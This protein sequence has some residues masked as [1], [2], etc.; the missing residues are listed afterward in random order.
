MAA[1]CSVRYICYIFS[2]MN[3]DNIIE[4]KYKALSKLAHGNFEAFLYDC[5]GTLADNMQ[6]HKDSYVKVALDNGIEI[7]PEIIDEFAGYP[8]PAV[9]EEINKRY[10]CSFDPLEFEKLKSTLFYDRYIEHTK[11]IEYVV[12]HLK[13]HSGKVKIGV[14]SGG[15]RVMIEKTLQV[16]GIASMVEVLVCAGETPNGKPFP[17]PFLLAAQKLAV[18]PDKCLVFEDGEPGVQA[19]IA[20]GMKWIRIDKVED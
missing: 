2:I 20:A 16:L 3:N 10:N 14:V 15:S 1:S 5:D 19:A 12:N 13:A 8:I 6:A 7:H 18:S 4:K 11:P 9:V 17:D